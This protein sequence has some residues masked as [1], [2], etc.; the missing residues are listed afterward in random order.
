MRGSRSVA[1]QFLTSVL[2]G[3]EW[4]VSRPLRFVPKVTAP[5]TH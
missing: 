4:S 5:G 2:D 1:P 3:G